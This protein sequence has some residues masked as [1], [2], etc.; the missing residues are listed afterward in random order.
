LGY[1]GYGWTNQLTP[2]YISLKEGFTVA[3]APERIRRLANAQMIYN[4]ISLML[5]AA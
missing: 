4:S 2:E 5:P 3:E 1:E